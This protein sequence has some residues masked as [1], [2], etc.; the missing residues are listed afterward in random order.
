MISGKKVV[1]GFCAAMGLV[2]IAGFVV[3]RIVLS[4]PKVQKDQQIMTTQ[5][6]FAY[7]KYR[8][9][10]KTWPVSAADAAEGFRSENNTLF[11][12]VG[13]AEQEWGMKTRVINP[14]SEKPLLEIVFEK[15]SHYERRHALYKQGQSRRNRT[16]ANY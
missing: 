3:V 12:R 10:N 11:D 5:L 2:A 9:D 4:M 1:F 14:D 16:S 7:Q 15:P 8:F 13:K 6:M